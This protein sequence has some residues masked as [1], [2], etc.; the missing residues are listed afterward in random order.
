MGIEVAINP[1]R[2][3]LDM[4]NDAILE[5]TDRLDKMVDACDNLQGA[6]DP[7]SQ[8]ARRLLEEH[9]QQQNSIA[10]GG[11]FFLRFLV[12]CITAP[13]SYALVKELP[14]PTERKLL[15]LI[16]KVLQN[17]SNKKEFGNKE[18]KML[19]FN[20][21]IVSNERVMADLFDRLSTVPERVEGTEP[22][23]WVSHVP[24]KYT[25][26]AICALYKHTERL[27]PKVL[28]SL[29]DVE[30]VNGDE[31]R[32][33]LRSQYARMLAQFFDRMDLIEVEKKATVVHEVNLNSSDDSSSSF[34]PEGAVVEQ[35]LDSSDSSS[36]ALPAGA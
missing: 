16:G 29:N 35:V 14:T 9:T 7:N 10:V 25:D 31:G 8:A 34:L 28:A 12:P 32:Q 36:D 17:L 6:L 2:Q 23:T 21:F 22:E 5:L 26:A 33:V 3:G 15:V 27:L 18:K 24:Q 4:F 13:E 11:F 20:D 19:Q 1:M 30:K